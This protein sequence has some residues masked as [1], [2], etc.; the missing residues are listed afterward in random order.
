[1]KTRIVPS[2]CVV[3]LSVLA[4]V[5]TFALADEQALSAGKL[6]DADHV[7]EI[8]I[9]LPAAD[10][11]T[12]RVQSRSFAKSLTKKTAVS[13]FVYV[14]G[15]ITIDGVLI[16][17]VG[18][19]KKGFLGSLDTQRPSLKVKFAEYTDQSPVE[20]LGRLTLNNNK[21][22]PSGLSQY[23]GY[24]FFN[25]SGTV[26]PRCNLARVTVNGK[27]LGIYSNVESIKPQM[28]EHGFGN[29]SGALFEG[30]IA[31]FYEDFTKK[32][33]KKNKQ[34]K[35]K[36]LQDISDILARDEVN[37]DRLDKL[38]DIEAFVRYWATESLLG[39]WDGYTNNQNNFFMYQNP[40]NSKFYF[41]PW[42]ADALFSEN[43]PLPP[44]RI[45]PRFVHSR[46]VL[47][48]RLY[49]IPRTQK[50]Y[51][52]TMTEL[53]EEH[54]NEK[55]L[56]AEV[57]R[58]EA[59]LKDLVRD[60]N[61]KFSDSVNKTRAFIKTRRQKLMKEME[62]GPV[63]LKSLARQPPYFT[64]I[65][66]ATISFTANWYDKTPKNPKDLG[67]V[68]IMLEMDG[69]RIEFEKIGVYAEHAKWPPKPQGEPKPPA[70]V[71]IGQRKPDGIT[72]TIATGLSIENFKPTEKESVDIGG[73]MIEGWSFFGRGMKILVGKVTF[74]S[75]KMKK[76]A[77]VQGTM[78]LTITQ[79][80]GGK[81]IAPPAKTQETKPDKDNAEP[82]NQ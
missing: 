57:D 54:W 1:M 23:L 4:S 2:T 11:D 5:Q 16:K 74:D 24:R 13:P 73:M 10:W 76:D 18:I 45:R 39:F 36:P 29:S 71:F 33:E 6:F 44:F 64:E 79:L 59:L 26:A 12:I 53:L 27:Y 52:E 9:E 82:I 37:V 63:E 30:T 47:A 22:D 61:T 8:S 67:D 15:D 55:E 66:K 78:E 68:E 14:K 75:A 56:L 34:A 28:L 58:M 40:K 46:A 80:R 38:V 31:D 3:A 42:G 65:G 60:R 32:F 69:K 21:Q 81:P 35:Y 77:T 51:H 7:V 17:G 72:M 20:G 41:I 19:R 70:I 43:M 50:L 48:N 62:G 49:R 25:K